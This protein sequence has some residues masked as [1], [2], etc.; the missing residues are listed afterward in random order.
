MLN[1]LFAVL[2]LTS[3]SAQIVF[4]ESLNVGVVQTVIEDSLEKNC[5]KLL[6]FIERAKAH[7]CQVVIFP[8]GALYWSDIAIDK[9]SRTDLDRAIARIGRKADSEDIYV[10]FGVGY[11]MTDTGPYL[12]RGVVYDPNGRRLLFY[13]KN[14][15]VPQRFFVDGVPFNL[16]ICSDRGYLEHSDLPCLV[17]GSQVIVD[18]S[19]GHG[20]DDGRPDLRWIRYRPWAMRTGAYVI[21]SNPVHDDTDF[22]GHNPWGGGSAVI[23]PDGSIQACRVY[24]KDCLIME[25]IDLSKATRLNAIRRRNHPIFKSFW[26]MGERLLKGDRV[27]SVPD[28]QPYSS[29]RR[30]ITIA[31]VQ[32]TCS[33]SIAENVEKIRRY[34]REAADQGADIVV[35]PELALT[36]IL[37]DDISKAQQSELQSALEEIRS[38]A[39]NRNIYVI[40]GMP[41]WVDGQRKNCAFVIGDDGSV[42][43]RYDQ[44]STIRDDVFQAGSNI[45][46]MWFELKGVHSIVT[47]GED[48]HFVEIGDLAAARGMVLHFHITNE[49]CSSS[50]EVTLFKQRHL[51]LLMYAKF[52]AVVNAGGMSMIV[53]REGGHNKP[54]PKGIE[55]YLPY[56]TS[57]IKSAGSA[58]TMILATRKTPARNDTDLLAYW[59]NRNRR[60][61]AQTGWYDW[62]KKGALLIESS[63]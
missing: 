1:R 60:N 53:S 32:I 20:G 62:I 45:K 46:A 63:Q 3:A 50:E 26:D 17:Q 27:D 40:V 2:L 13:E 43:T 35:F 24:E 34:I 10:I 16:S 56:Q 31:A 37:K 57:I 21:V 28:I 49:T 30:D 5:S 19:G 14:T 42:K 61:R 47:I 52:G 18:I 15:E 22:M 58:E 23:R 48:V 39:D 41:Y 8:E 4:S 44:V 9:P 38:E 12:N 59:R 51:L 36:G 29:A 33:R 54:A 6:G 7:K 25:D 11:R 55:Y